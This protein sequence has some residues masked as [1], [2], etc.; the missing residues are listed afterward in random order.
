MA[1]FE[2]AALALADVQSIMDHTSEKWGSEQAILYLESLR[3][4]F[5]RLA[6]NPFVGVARPEL[7]EAV[8]MFPHKVHLIFYRPTASGVAIARVL[9]GRQD[10][11]RHLNSPS[12]G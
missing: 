1:R 8:R 7:G 12:D 10:P 11:F 6:E 4:A 2:L 9:H 3:L 5:R